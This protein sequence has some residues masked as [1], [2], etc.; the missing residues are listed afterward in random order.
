MSERERLLLDLRRIAG[1]GYLLEKGEDAQEYLNLM[2]RHIG[3][4]DAELRDTL[5][6]ETF[7]QWI[8]E[9]ARLS[10]DALRRILAVL[11]DHDHL[12]CHMGNDGDSTVLTRS[13]SVLAVVQILAEHRKRAILDRELFEQTKNAIVRYCAQEMDLRGYQ[14]DFG[15]AHAAAHGADALEELVQCRECDAAAIR[16]IL[17]CMKRMMQNGRYLLCHEE[18]ERLVRAAH[19]MLSGPAAFRALLRAFMKDVAAYAGADDP[20]MQYIARVNTK[21]FVRSFYFRLL[22][23]NTEEDFRALLADVEKQMNRFAPKTQ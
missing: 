19:H 1:N 18:D 2:L 17:A 10:D 13:F 5:I 11:L 9:K 7:C 15:W 23:A 21:N 20:R 4:T 22:H 16:E 3:D 12:F 8:S 14:P 6:Y